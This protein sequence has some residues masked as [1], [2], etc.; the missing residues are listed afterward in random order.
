MDAGS[1]FPRMTLSWPS[2]HLRAS[3]S[4]VRSCQRTWPR[5]FAAREIFGIGKTVAAFRSAYSRDAPWWTAA[6]PSAGNGS[7]MRIAPVILPHVR[8]P[9]PAL[10]ADAVLGGP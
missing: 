3:S 8:R 2:G 5:V 9:S 1:G 7:L 6:Q 4:T 10:W